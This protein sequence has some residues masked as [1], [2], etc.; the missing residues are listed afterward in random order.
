MNLDTPLPEVAT[1]LAPVTAEALLKMPV[2]IQEQTLKVVRAWMFSLEMLSD[3]P[4]DPISLATRLHD[5]VGGAM[6]AFAQGEVPV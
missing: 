2:G 5:V 3:D 4:I 1:F 6:I